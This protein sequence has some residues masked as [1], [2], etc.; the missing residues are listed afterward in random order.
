MRLLWEMFQ[1][2]HI[3]EPAAC[4]LVGFKI[5]KRNEVH[6]YV[7]YVYYLSSQ[8]AFFKVYTRGSRYYFDPD[9]GNTHS[10]NLVLFDE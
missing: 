5:L 10:D 6:Q 8:I 7:I 2:L 3:L 4:L 1:I 9:G